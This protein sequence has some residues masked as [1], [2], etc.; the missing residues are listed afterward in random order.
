MNSR[1]FTGRGRRRETRRGVRVAERV[2]RTLISIGGI[3][4]IAAVVLIFV[5]LVW[6]VVPLF[7]GAD[8]E[9]GPRAVLAAPSAQS[10]VAREALDEYR[11]LVL[12][13][14][15]DGSIVA[16]RVEDGS[17]L[18]TQRLFADA[19]PTAVSPTDPSGDVA[20]GFADGSISLGRVGFGTEFVPSGSE[21]A[22]ITSL[23]AGD[24]RVLGGALYERLPDGR[25]RRQ[26]LRV[27]VD[28]RRDV[29]AR[30]AV[31]ALDR[32]THGDRTRLVVHDASGDLVLVEFERSENLLTGEVELSESHHVVS[33]RRRDG[34]APTRA[35][36]TG[37]G[38]SAFLVWDDGWLQRYDVRDPEAAGFAEE[39]DLVED[40]GRLTAVAFLLG[41]TTLVTGDSSGRVRGWFTTKPDGAGTRDG[42]RLQRAHELA[43][44]GPAVTT[45]A[46][47]ARS[48]IVAAG[49]ADGAVKLYHVTSHKV[50]VDARAADGAPVEALAVA[51]KDDALFASAGGR[52]T[53]W[54]MELGHPEATLSALFT[55]V[56]YEGYVRPEHAWQ[57]TSGTDDF[58][59]KLGLWPL[60]FGTLKATFYS[61]LFGAPL[62][63]LAAV[64]TSEF[65]D[66][67]FKVTIKSVTEL[68]ASLPSVVLGFLAAI[69]IA[70]FLQG[71][72]AA[73]LAA[74]FT[75]PLALL[76]GAHL[77][78]LLPQKSYVRLSGLPRFAAIA[79]CLPVGILGAVWLGPAVERAFF[80]G[81]VKAWLSSSSG[82]SVGGWLLLLLPLSALAVAIA[83]GRWVSPWVRRISSDWD[84]ARC[85]RFELVRLAAS[86]LAVVGVALVLA[87]ALDG[88]GVDSRGG[89]LDTY[90]QGN[91][92]VV[93]FVM[94][95]AI[96]PIIYTLAEDALSSVPVHLR[97][98]SLG[99][100]ATPWQT[101]VRVVIPTAMS[102]LFSALMIGLGRAVGE[103]MIVVMAAGNTAVTSWNVFNG[104]RTLSAN[105]ATE[106]P[107]AVRDSTH[108]RT[109]FLA[110]FCLFALTFALNTVAEFVRQRFRKRAYQL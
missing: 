107:E 106:M 81:D 74:L 24:L 49:F 42:V 98:A 57:S 89:V 48:R 36:L 43:T 76:L 97:L 78:Q 93:G 5:F 55:P 65:L 33:T 101:A 108:Y 10:D 11:R 6:V 18:A 82:S 13:L 35:F 100:G 72:L 51:P 1:S 63:L 2:A 47:S 7:R 3:G 4:T 64:F 88:A 37:A 61:L 44:S 102:G 90:S 31:T 95:F 27:Q 94:G 32:S 34:A 59:P 91:A 46:T 62:A 67:R 8:H 73:V 83:S 69:V 80:G 70:P 103:T 39:L 104:F 12:E 54:N 92:L 53:T 110:A 25:L 38:D 26:V 85:G 50:L 77:W 60:V 71:V 21:P 79:A 30:G 17:V 20:F 40:D 41:R 56:W 109:L 52:S 87:F 68:M 19:T 23:V 84:R 75:I 15:R 9:L 105:I 58:E 22:E 45:L 96:V 14:H 28:E 29:G 66:K 16:R 99:A 86:V